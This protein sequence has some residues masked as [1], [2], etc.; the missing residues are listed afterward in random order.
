MLFADCTSN[1]NIYSHC[2]WIKFCTMIHRHGNMTFQHGMITS[3]SNWNGNC[4][5]RG[6]THRGHGSRYNTH[7]PNGGGNKS[8]FFCCCFARRM[9]GRWCS[10]S[11]EGLPHVLMTQQQHAGFHIH[12]Q[13]IPFQQMPFKYYTLICLLS[14]NQRKKGHNDYIWGSKSDR[15]YEPTT[16]EEEWPEFGWTWEW[17]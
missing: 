5:A 14:A 1:R 8:L 15:V 4:E 13:I 12:P 17:I 3:V 9:W 16:A 6:V 10:H 2:I 7:L 11:L